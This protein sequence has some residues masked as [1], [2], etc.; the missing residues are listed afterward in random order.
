M[1]DK[2]TDYLGKE[3]KPGQTIV[4]PGRKGSALWIARGKVRSVS[5]ATDKFPHGTVSILTEGDKERVLIHPYRVAVVEE[6][7]YM[8]KQNP[9]AQFLN[10]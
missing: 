8:T 6:Q 10:G 4:Y 3:I 5:T 9:S 1:G 7:D 2:V